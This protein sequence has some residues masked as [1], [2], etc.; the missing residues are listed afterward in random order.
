MGMFC[1]C[2][3]YLKVVNQNNVK[4][5]KRILNFDMVGTRDKL[6]RPITKDG[7]TNFES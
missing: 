5:I 7:I 2:G 4:G 1:M 6:M 3:T